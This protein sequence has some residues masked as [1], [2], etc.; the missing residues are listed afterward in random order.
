MALSHIET[1]NRRLGERLGLVCGGTLPRF[2]WKYAP[3]LPRFMYDTDNRTLLKRTW[4]DA[5]APDGNCIGKVWFLAEHR[6]S[7]AIDHHGYS[8]AIRVP[9][10]KEADYAPYL[11][12][13]LAPGM[14]PTAALTQNYIFAIDHQMQSSFENYMAEEKYTADRNKRREAEAWRETVRAGFDQHT[15]A[16]GNCI[17]GTA[18]GFL[19]FGGVGPDRHS[20]T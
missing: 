4:A 19:S 18:G 15:G 12:T 14:L 9:F 8:A 5:P 11:E 1:L 16:M 13:A 7:K 17:P 20:H 10:I 6:P 3:D 2:A